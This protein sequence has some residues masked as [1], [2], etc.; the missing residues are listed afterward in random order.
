MLT[1]SILS[2]AYSVNLS[3]ILFSERINEVQALR[4]AEGAGLS[5]PEVS[6][7]RRRLEVGPR[8]AKSLRVI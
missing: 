5:E 2:S 6:P 8:V 1:F 3:F 4:L 7:A